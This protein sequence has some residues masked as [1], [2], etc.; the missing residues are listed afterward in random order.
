MH[1][2]T[3]SELLKIVDIIHINC[4]I[5]KKV[6][7]ILKIKIMKKLTK[8]LIVIGR[9]IFKIFYYLFKFIF[10]EKLLQFAHGCDTLPFFSSYSYG[11]VP[12]D[13]FLF[14]YKKM[15]SGEKVTSNDYNTAKYGSPTPSS[16]QINNAWKRRESVKTLFSF[17]SI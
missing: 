6:I 11:G 12:R 16:G 13:K 2:S 4:N 1:F 17:E 14:F 10:Q 7:Y 9:T 8:I 3:E 15:K 5:K